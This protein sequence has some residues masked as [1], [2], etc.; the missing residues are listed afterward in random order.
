M[1]AR[2]GGYLANEIYIHIA[3]IIVHWVSDI[4]IFIYLLFTLFWKV[5]TGVLNHLFN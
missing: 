1:R 2:L 3:E 4:V 5:N